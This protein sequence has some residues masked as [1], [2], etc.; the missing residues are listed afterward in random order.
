MSSTQTMEIPAEL[1][2]LSAFVDQRQEMLATG[3]DDIRL[4]AL[5]ATK[6]LYDLALKSEAQSRGHIAEL[7]S[8]FSPSLAPQTRSQTATSSKRNTDDSAHSAQN[9]PML[10]ETPLSELIV[11]DMHE[12]QIWAQ[13]ELRTKNVCDIMGYVLEGA[14]GGVKSDDEDVT[15]DVTRAVPGG[16]TLAIDEDIDMDGLDDIKS[17]SEDDGEDEGEV[18]SDSDKEDG[19]DEKA[20]E[21]E[22]LGEN[23]VE[24][25][26]SSDEENNLEKGFGLG[27]PSPRSHSAGGARSQSKYAGRSGLDDGFFNLA[28]FNRETEE[29][30]AKEASKG[31]LGRDDSED[32]GEDDEPLDLFAPVN[33]QLDI[34]GQG[35]EPNEP[36]YK[37]FFDPPPRLPPSKNGAKQQTGRVRFHEEVRVKNIKAKGKNLPTSMLYEMDDEDEDDEGSENEEDIIDVDYDVEA[38]GKGFEGSMQGSENTEGDEEGSTN[39][40]SVLDE[41]SDTNGQET[42]ER[43]KDD[44][45]AEEEE[46]QQP[47][48]STYEKRMAALREEIAALEAE[49]VAKKTWTLMGEATSRTRPQ[50][51]LLEEDLEYERVMKSVPV[52]TEDTVRSLEERIKARILESQY[53]DVIRKRPADDKPFLPSR[54]F[55]LQDTKSKQSLAEIYEDEYTATQTGAA[56]GEDRDGKLRKEQQEVEKLW[57]SIA[58]K[59]DALCNAHFTPKAPKATISTVGNV[60]A[61]SM[62]SALPTTMSTSSMLAPEEVFAPPTSTDFH[63]RSELTPTKKRALRNKQKKAKKQARDVLEKSVDKFAQSKRV[64]SVKKQKEAALK[65]V[66]KSGKGITVVGKKAKD[67]TRKGGK[68]SRVKS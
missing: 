41:D 11:D 25:R 33:D 22:D 42:M 28:T 59:L 63:A 43:F 31:R 53:N 26:D 27:Q 52:I 13:L 8:S 36:L 47:D 17:D 4:A 62:E 68:E 54:F 40:E 49:N 16:R 38:W 29:A 51:S 6:F 37:D 55:E 64:G 30:E 48:M 65:S 32:E 1:Q 24:L 9:V 45:F 58:G 61:A 50:N 21:E 46:E 5:K 23:I 18:T 12:D 19:G 39:D 10:Q 14:V 34:D 15:E 56:A 57:E 3:N 44:L 20:E 35:G 67:V 60:A 2:S 66:V 7:L